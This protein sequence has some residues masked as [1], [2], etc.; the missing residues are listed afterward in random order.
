MQELRRAFEDHSIRHCNR[1]IHDK[2]FNIYNVRLKFLIT[3]MN[4]WL[5]FCKI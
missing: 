2:R 4:L 1:T 5:I 3:R